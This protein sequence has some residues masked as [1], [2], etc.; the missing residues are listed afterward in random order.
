MRVTASTAPNKVSTWFTAFGESGILRGTSHG[1]ETMSARA[2]LTASILALGAAAG[3]AAADTRTPAEV[4]PSSYT[5]SQYVDSR[6]CVYVRAGSGGMVSWIPRMDR[7][8]EHICNAQPTV[9]AGA[10]T[11][12]LTGRTTASAADA[13]VIASPPPVRAPV[14]S[15]AETYRAAAAASVAFYTSPPAP[16]PVTTAQGRP[17][18]SCTG[19]SPLSAQYI[20]WGQ[21]GPVRCGPQP[22]H[23]MDAARRLGQVAPAAAAPYA[24]AGANPPFEPV[25]ANPQ[26]PAGYRVAWSDGRLN[27]N[28][29][30]QGG[31]YVAATAPLAT[32]VSTRGEPAPVARARTTT[33]DTPRAA[34]APAV[35]AGQRFVQVGTYG[36]PSNAERAAARLQ[37]MGFPVARRAVTSGGRSLQIV[38]AGP[39]GSAS[40]VAAAL[41]AARQAGYR[42]AFAR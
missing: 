29:G 17:P 14:R 6:G 20:N 15:D 34:A 8:R 12:P 27:P 22:E 21:H 23:P 4:P 1:G 41:G 18:A 9:V 19:A 11:P 10:T 25:N 40:E 33:D 5:G 42:D 30:P 26:V 28:R 39:F 35:S 38:M 7:S 36:V 2:V 31:V 13:Y 24:Y 16:A 37:G 32:T 3:A